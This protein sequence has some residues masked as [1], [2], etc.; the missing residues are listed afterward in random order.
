MSEA[1]RLEVLNGVDRASKK[2]PNMNVEQMRALFASLPRDDKGTVLFHDVQ[3][4][5]RVCLQRWDA[6]WSRSRSSVVC[7]VSLPS[8]QTPLHYVVVVVVVVIVGCYGLLAVVCC[9]L[10]FSM[11]VSVVVAPVFLRSRV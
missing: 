6:P 1:Q 11:A 5:V 8:F 4:Y 10:L 2:L 7:L 9:L 3:R